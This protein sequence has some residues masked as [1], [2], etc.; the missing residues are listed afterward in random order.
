LVT[1][2]KIGRARHCRLG[3]H[4]LED[5]TIW[6]GMYQRMLDARLNRLEAFLEHTKG[7]PS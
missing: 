5:E 4:R 1:T 2:E 6:I 7:K 3:P